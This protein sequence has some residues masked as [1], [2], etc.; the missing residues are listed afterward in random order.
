MSRNTTGNNDE[1]V[2]STCHTAMNR[3]SSRSLLKCG[4]SDE[5]VSHI[6]ESAIVDKEH[7]ASICTHLCNQLRTIINL[8]IDFAG[9]VCDESATARSLLRELEDKVMP[10]LVNLDIEM[11]LSEK[12]IRINIDTARISET[13]VDW[14]LKFNKCKLEMR[15]MLATLS[16]AVYEDL[17]RVLSLRCR[18]CCGMNFKKE[19]MLCLY[20][21]KK[22]TDKLQKEIKLEQTALIH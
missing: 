16:G 1:I 5:E 11:A 4:L 17:E 15:E 3:R 10:F 20:Q 21:M 6:C 9:D 12:L 14:L 2:S 22:G 13:K 8:L 19:L 7:L 18:G